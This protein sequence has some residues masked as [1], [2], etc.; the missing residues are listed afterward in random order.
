MANRLAKIYVVLSGAI[1]VIVGVVGFYRHEMFNLKFPLE[2]NLFHLL[3]G[4]IALWM[5]LG[6]RPNGVREFGLIFGAVYTALAIAGFAG[7]RDLGPV[8][9]ALNSHYNV[10]HL[11]IGILSLTA[12]FLATKKT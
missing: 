7:L 12:G 2:H 1:L 8:H 3:S 10:I 6:P 11:G 5:G 4:M 9:L